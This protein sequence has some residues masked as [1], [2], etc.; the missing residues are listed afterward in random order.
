MR[1]VD[2]NG[3]RT[4]TLTEMRVSRLDHAPGAP[5]ACV[6][7]EGA[8]GPS[9]SMTV[10]LA[11]S[12][13]ASLARALTSADAN[14]SAACDLILAPARRLESAVVRAVIDNGPD[15]ISAEL[16]LGH[17]ADP[18]LLACDVADALTLAVRARAPI[19]ATRRALDRPLGNGHCASSDGLASSW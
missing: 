14:C 2:R 12:D 1:I 8:A 3:T 11:S 17:D 18:F 9:R 5:I 6:L 16:A 19:Y 10:V 15:E 7:L 13:A 4:A